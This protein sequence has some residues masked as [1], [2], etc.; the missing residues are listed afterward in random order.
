MCL[1]GLFRNS[2]YY[3]VTQDTTGKILH[4]LLCYIHTHSKTFHIQPNN[5][6]YLIYTLL[7]TLIEYLA[8]SAGG[9]GVHWAKE[10]SVLV[11]GPIR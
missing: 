1:C 7:L 2:F 5:D 3:E 10:S 9:D 8:E 4:L 6:L 11:T